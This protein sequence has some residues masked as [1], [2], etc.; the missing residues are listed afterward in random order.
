MSNL[1]RPTTR[2]SQRQPASYQILME[3]SNI[4]QYTFYR[5]IERKT[6]QEGG[7][8]PTLPRTSTDVYEQSSPS[9][10][11]TLAA[12][13]SKL[14]NSHRS[15]C[16]T[17]IHILQKHRAQNPAGRRHKPDSSSHQHRRSTR[18]LPHP[19]TGPTQNQSRELPN[20]HGSSRETGIHIL[21]KDQA[22]NPAREG[23]KPESHL[24]PARMPSFKIF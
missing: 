10:H 7:L 2:P 19:T 4:L 1:P 16:E 22:Q 23:S 15:S 9:N 21:E 11:S 17:P 8:N 14:S 3:A 5:N 12:T 24:G 13:I 20:S 18:H 6:L